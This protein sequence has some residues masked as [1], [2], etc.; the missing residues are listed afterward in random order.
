MYTPA[1]AFFTSRYSFTPRLRLMSRMN[2]A[3]CGSGSPPRH[4]WSR[5]QK[6]GSYLAVTGQVAGFCEINERFLCAGERN[7]PADREKGRK[8][9]GRPCSCF[10]FPGLLPSPPLVRPSFHLYFLRAF[11]SLDHL[12]L[13]IR[14]SRAV[15]FHETRFSSNDLSTWRLKESRMGNW[16]IRVA[17][18]VTF[19][20]FYYD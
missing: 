7:C 3:I 12:N 20:I 19:C 2:A 17:I 6:R 15:Y 9:V 16:L 4:R 14:G 5:N 18:R 8:E 11:F 1:L 13:R 10:Q